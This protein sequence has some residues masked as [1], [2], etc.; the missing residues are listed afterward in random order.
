MPGP[1]VARDLKFQGNKFS[2]AVNRANLMA[3]EQIAR[4]LEKSSGVRLTRTQVLQHLISFY[5]SRKDP[6]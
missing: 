5:N 6:S 4:D 3:M 1:K 2:M